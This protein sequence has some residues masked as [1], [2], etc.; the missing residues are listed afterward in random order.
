MCLFRSIILF[1]FAAAA[2]G[3]GVEFRW[4]ILSPRWEVKT[5]ADGFIPDS[6]ST[7]TTVQEQVSLPAPPPVRQSWKRLPSERTL[8]VLDARL[9]K[10]MEDL[11]RDYKFVIEDP[12]TGAQ[13][14]AEIPDPDAYGSAKYRPAFRKARYI[15]DSVADRVPGYSDIRFDP[16]PLVRVTG[17]GFFDQAHYAPYHGTAPN[18]REIHPV[19]RI[20][21]VR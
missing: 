14:L 1:L 13:M 11:D 2:A 15:I 10:V 4:H 17:I 18:N 8:Y 7:P 19:L 9:V 21:V 12:K 6:I 3:S 5:L 20:E 16:E